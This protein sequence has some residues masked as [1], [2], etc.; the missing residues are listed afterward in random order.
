MNKTIS[1]L[2]AFI[3]VALCA[4]SLLLIMNI[5]NDESALVFALHAVFD[6]GLG[7]LGFYIFHLLYTRWSKI[8]PWIS[9]CDKYCKKGMDAPNPFRAKDDNDYWQ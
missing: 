4:V 7:I 2:R 3:L 9:A 6:K 5:E 8:D 1:L